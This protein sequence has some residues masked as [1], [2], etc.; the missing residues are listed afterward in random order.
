MRTED[1][2]VAAGC[3]L[4]CCIRCSDSGVALGVR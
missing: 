4:C 3:G 1:A 2:R